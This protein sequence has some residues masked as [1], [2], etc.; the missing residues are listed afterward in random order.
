MC[1]VCLYV[2]KREILEP[3]AEQDARYGPWMDFGGGEF[4]QIWRDS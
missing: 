3:I 1:D 4:K 2:C